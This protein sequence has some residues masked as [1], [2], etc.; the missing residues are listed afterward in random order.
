MKIDVSH[1]YLLFNQKL[2]IHI[3]KK[4]IISVIWFMIVQIRNLS[5]QII[6]AKLFYSFFFGCC[7]LFLLFVCLAHW[8]ISW[9]QTRYLSPDWP[10]TLHV[11]WL[12][13]DTNL[14]VSASIVLELQVWATMPNYFF[15]NFKGIFHF[16]QCRPSWSW[17]YSTPTLVS[18]VLGL[19]KCTTVHDK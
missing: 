9:F 18:W 16:T 8:L 7:C 5:I 19:Q 13:S 14:P 1:N 4:A 11:T 15:S 6:W 3:S 2:A 17:P 12:P 10:G